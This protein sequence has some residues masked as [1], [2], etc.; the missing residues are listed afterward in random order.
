ME[1]IL[2][3]LCG[4]GPEDPLPLWVHGSIGHCFNQLTLNVIPHVVLAVVSACFLGTPR[5]GSEVPHQ[6]GWRCRIAASFILTGLFVADIIP[7]AIS[8][9][10][11]GPVYLEVLASGIA[12]LTWLTHGAAL[13]MLCR[14]IHGSTRGPAALALL[15][16]L[17]LPSLIITLV[18]YC[19]SGTAW[20]PA[21]PAVSSRFTILCLQLVSLLVYVISCLLPTP[22]RHKFLS[23]N[24]SWQPDQLISEPGISVSG[25]QQVAEDG[26]SWLSRFFYAWMNPLMKCGYQ[27]KLN[28]PQ[29]VY[30]LPRQLQAA[31]V[32]DR[33][34]ACW[35][36]KAALHQVEE[37]TVSLTSP[38]IAAGDGSGGVQD[39]LH[40]AQ[41][42]VRLFSV[43]H[44]VFGPRFYLLG[45]LKLAG[46][47]LAFSGPLLLNLLVN[48]MESRQEPL[49]HGVLY[50]LGLFAG[51][52]LGA[53][54]RNQ[55]SYEVNKVTLMVRAAVISAIY[56]KALRVSSTS[57]SRFTVGEIVNFMSTDTSRLVNFCLSFHEVWSLPFQFAITLYL[58]Y[59]Q[60]GVAFLGGLALALLLVPINKVIANRIM[61]SNKEM[62]QHKDAR[63]KLMTE[64]LSGIR[65]IKFY[66]WEKHFSTRINACRAKELQKLRA[67]KYLDAVCVYLWAALP[68]VVSI[69]IFITYVL[70][71]HQLTA[72]K[73]FTALA[74]VGMLILPL[75]SF[76][77]VLNGT[78]EAKVSLDRIQRFLELVDQDL[79]AYYALGNPSGTASAIE[80]QGADFS[81]APGEEESSSQPLPTGS[82]QLHIE[83]LSVRKGMLLG[84]VGKVGSGKSSLLAAITG[85]LIKQ[86]GQVYVCDLEQGFGLAT[87]E[88]WIQFTTVRE[89]IL[90]GRE[91]D[92]R[93]YEEVVEACALSEDLNILPAGDQTE[94]GENGVTLSGGQ[95]ARIALA[96][97]VYQE[98]ELYLLD[99]PLAAVD[100]NVASHLMRKCV[101]GVLQH[102]TRILC[103]HRTEFLEKADALLLM[104]NGRIVKTG[105]PADILPLVEAIPKFKDVDKRQKHKA[106]DE[107]SQEE[108]IETEAE[109]SP[110]DNHLLH[111]EE[112][113]KEGAVAF[114]VYKAYW[115]AVGSCLALS[116]L[117]SLLLMQASRN[118]S[119][120]WLSHW[121]SSISQTANTSVM[122]CSASLPSAELLLFSTVGLVSPVQALDTAPVPS[123]GSADVNF[124]LMVYGSIAG[125]NSLFTIFRAFLFAYG[126]IRAATVIHNRLLQRVIKATVT[127]FDTT[128]TG[129]ILNRFSSD[130]YCV[131]DSLP[132]ILNIF[133]A[134]IYGLLGML[135]I[136]TYGLPWV[137]LVLLPLAALYFS[138]QRYYRR[139]SRELKRLYS[140]T[141][142][143][144]YTHFSETLSGLSS[145]RAMRAAQRFELENQLRLE[146][147]QRCL[148]ASNTAMQWLDIRLQMI[149][150]AV[151]T[152]I[153]GIAIIQHQKHLGNPGLVGLALSYALS[154]TNLLSGLISSFTM[155]ETMMVSV[156]R[157][158]E[159]TT[160]IPVEPQDKVVQVAA[161]WP[162]QGLVEFQHVV[163]AYRAGLPNALDGVSFTVYPGEKVGIVGRTGS[164]KSTLF[165][166]LFRMLE[167]KAGRILLD[168]V[169]SRLVG[170]EE[171]RSRLAIIPQDPFLFSGSIRENLDPQ[172]K[173]TDAE[174]HEVLEQCHL[175]DAVTQMG[176][177]DSELGERGKCLSVGQRQL[178]CLARALLTQAKV[179]CIDEATASVDQKTDQLLQQTIRQRFAD[180]TV[181]T[182][183][184][185]LNTI[186]DSDRVLVMQA[187]RVAELDS[188]SYLSKKDGSLFQRLLHSGQQ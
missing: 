11:L 59:Q 161:D 78:L 45:L 82:L 181:L 67:I 95:K 124:Y 72:T 28:Q 42:P 61:M 160:D 149:G 92:A 144:I 46:S 38:I 52:F 175:W 142:S 116:I 183:A 69:V 87:Q 5:S 21:H 35:Q 74:L 8:Q 89:N 4:T 110:Q 132:F 170:L 152:A 77:W 33:F 16:L 114:Q 27:W 113:K 133:L 104:D 43:L 62:L 26:E 168:G 85:E 57:L 143:P 37:E 53:L 184:H 185:R 75:N 71:G 134:N 81:W 107:Q 174:L 169:D 135:V 136:I 83:N 187:G 98:K 159:Y 126:T 146:Q 120:W 103:T 148:F 18:W 31:R 14:S 51:S 68:V 167:L 66:A 112:E 153:A 171:L 73:V 109:E 9:Q 65:V 115:L 40:R 123:N 39:S 22:D 111:K 88:P 125:A 36:K 127:F 106:P 140:L 96:R 32:C 1:N 13:L 102:K 108:D 63:V 84:V 2:T 49:S 105:T 179:L 163:L 156:E 158:E 30:L 58:L 24:S 50:A 79:E 176:G 64:F 99:D 164:G 97:A 101:L 20:S 41:E 6:P 121:I 166:A 173:R 118:I 154:V 129:R 177:L 93:L 48:F 54:L 76:P 188:P 128:P 55:F 47:L 25:Q 3:G 131:D 29:D 34:Y 137:G 162:S 178:V 119:D 19:R 80:M 151:V 150:V 15:T 157:T 100:A 60:V 147:N 139:T 172:G 90:F 122:V 56:R 186:L 130:L 91:Y 182:I 145:I 165:L 180:K 117:F 17:P 155:T 7:A 94:V 138:I 70:L 12:A 141:L 44:A 86:G 23:I 10:E